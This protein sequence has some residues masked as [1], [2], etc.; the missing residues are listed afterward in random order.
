VLTLI[1]GVVYP[2]AMT[3]LAS[4]AFNHQASGSF[5]V[6]KGAPVGSELI[7]QKFSS[8][9]YFHSRPSAID[10]NPLPSSGSNFG[11]TSKAMQDSIAMYKKQFAMQNDLQA[12]IT[13]PKEMVSMS[14]SGLD[15]HISPEAALMQ[16]GRIA[17]VRA[18][19][20]QKKAAL[21]ALVN[22]LT[23][24]PEF[25]FLG[26]PRVNVLRLNIA[27]DEESSLSAINQ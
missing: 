23:E 5:I 13:F 3:L 14:A 19:S 15:P 8:P 24:A 16:V 10:Y 1:T 11:P 20:E 26:Q 7:G 25:G 17:R 18:F 9:M 27:L 2:L 22:R 4:V 12:P 21:A 6:Y